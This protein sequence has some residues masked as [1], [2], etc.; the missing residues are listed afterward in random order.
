MHHTH[1]NTIYH[2]EEHHADGPNVAL[3]GVTLLPQRL[4]RH[5]KRRTHVEVL[6]LRSSVVAV[7]RHG[8]P[9]ISN[10]GRRSIN[11]YVGRFDVAV[12]EAYV[13]YQNKYATFLVDLQETRHHVL[14]DANRFA[15]IDATTPFNARTQ[16]PRITVL[17]NQV[18]VVLRLKHVIQ[19]QDVLAVEGLQRTDLVL[20]QHRVDGLLY[21]LHVDHL[22]G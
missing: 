18:G 20:Q 6:A 21:H 16:V 14:Q 19:L 2:F 9:K 13:V 7:Q 5:V 17:R 1:T 3:L 8:E 10:L 15:L 4:R 22:W 12:N 11:Q